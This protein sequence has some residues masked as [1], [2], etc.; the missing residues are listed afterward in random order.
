MTLGTTHMDEGRMVD[1]KALLKRYFGYDEFRPL[2]R[3]VIA[4]ALERR[5][6]LVVMPTGGGKSLCYQI[7]A[8]ALDGLTLVV[9]PLIALMKDQVDALK[10]NGVAAEFIN[11]TLSYDEMRRIQTAAQDG[12]VK[13]L[14][15][16]PE[17]LALPAFQ[18]FLDTLKISLVAVDEAHCISEWGHDFR[19]DYRSLGALRRSMPHTP[20][21]ALTATATEQVRQDIVAQIGLNNPQAFI[22]SFNRANLN[23]EV[24]PKRNAFAAVCELLRKHRDESAIIYCFSRKD[25]EYLAAQLRDAGFDALP[26]HAGLEDDVRRRNQERFIRDQT[27]IIA[28]TIAFGMGIDKPDVRLVV[29]HNLP[30]TI[31]GYYQ[32]TGRAGRDGLPSDCVLFYSY[33]DKIKQDFFIN[34]IEDE[35]ERQNAQR[36]LEQVIEFCELNACRRRY[37]L[38]YFGESDAQP[39]NCGA[40]DNCLAPTEEFDATVIAQKILSAII[41]TGQRFGIFYISLVL[42]GS[43]VKRVIERGHDNLSVYGIVNDYTDD[44]IKEIAGALLERG[45]LRKNDGDYPTFGVTPEGRRFLNNRETLTLTRRLDDEYTPPPASSAARA[46]SAAPAD[47]DAELFQELRAL[48]TQIA[49]RRGV[50][51]YVV[52]GDVTLRQMAAYFPQN[53]ADL[54]RIHGVG[55]VKLE[56]YGDEFLVVI[57]KYAQERSLPDRMPALQ[58]NSD[59]DKSYSV[60]TIRQKHPKAYEKW[61]TEE[62]ERLMRQS[63]IGLSIAELSAMFERGPGA[64]QSR[65]ARLGIETSEDGQSSSEEHIQNP[66]VALKE[67]TYGRTRRLLARGFSIEQAAEERDLSENAIVAHIESLV[68]NGISVDLRPHLPHEERVERI[69]AAFELGGLDSALT[70]VKKALGDDC[71]YNEIKLVRAFL[72]QQAAAPEPDGGNP[73]TPNLFNL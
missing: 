33:G 31:E 5:D 4:C 51:P 27:P 42:R 64:I 70:P 10:A 53:R 29:H 12:A 17:R 38:D 71:T 61:S 22:A 40:C 48:R 41:R 24:R 11:S 56:Q 66:S 36:K 63:R 52:F 35:A 34:R 26:Y 49:S 2:Q 59:D 72:I 67:S 3:E 30:K 60:D 14:Y 46:Q 1:P 8:L 13:I 21:I 32:E 7:P 55:S 25:T 58:T 37:L 50:P 73:S 57:K 16:A 43:K 19:P 68:Q 6:A 45:L 18:N 65:L 9:S 44:D 62:D 23:Y 28:A 20:F 47:Y 69:K 15:L 39:P 54:A